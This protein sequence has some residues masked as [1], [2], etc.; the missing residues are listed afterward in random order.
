M[1]RDHP[2]RIIGVIASLAQADVSGAE[3]H[4]RLTRGTVPGLDAYEIP[5]RTVQ[6]YAQRARFDREPIGED[7]VASVN[8]MERRILRIVNR[9]LN[10]LEDKQRRKPLST[11]ES[12]AL[13]AH[14]GTVD[15]VRTSR[16]RAAKPAPDREA[17]ERGAQGAVAAAASPRTVAERIAAD[18]KRERNG[19]PASPELPQAQT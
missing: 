16:R 15:A 19:S 1:A 12:Q 14:Y 5:L 13:R 2:D 18:L 10:R 4:R 17:S 3:I 8:A 9:E 6:Q 11:Q 7:D